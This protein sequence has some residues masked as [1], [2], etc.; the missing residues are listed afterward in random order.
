MSAP[1]TSATS[2]IGTFGSTRWY[3]PRIVAIASASLLASP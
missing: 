2:S 1:T 3:A